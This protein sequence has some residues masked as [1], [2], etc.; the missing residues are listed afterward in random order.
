VGQVVT[1]DPN[2]PGYEINALYQLYNSTNGADWEYQGTGTHWAFTP[3]ANPCADGWAGITCILP[4]PYTTNYINQLNLQQF[5]LQGSLPDA[6]GNFHHMS[7]LVLNYNEITGSIPSTITNLTGLY[8]LDIMVNH[9]TGEIPDVFN[10]MPKLNNIALDYNHLN[11]TIPSTIVSLTTIEYIGLSYNHLN[12]TIPEGFGSLKLL[13][14]IEL[15]SNMLSGSIPASLCGLP[16]LQ[17]LDIAKNHLTGALPAELGA[18]SALQVL[19]AYGNFL[20]GSLPASMGNLTL[21][22]DFTVYDNQLT[23]SLPALFGRLVNL[24]IFQADHNNLNGTFPAGMSN[25]THLTTFTVQSNKFSGTLPGELFSLPLLDDLVLSSNRFNGT[26]PDSIGNLTLV[27]EIALSY[28]ELTGSIP[29]A[30]GKLYMVQSL[31]FSANR[32]VGPLPQGLLDLP[33]LNAFRMFENKLTGPFPEI[34]CEIPTLTIVGL[35][36][37]LFH[38]TLPACISQLSQLQELAIQQNSWTGTLPPEYGDLANLRVITLQFCRSLHGTIPESYAN[39]QSLM[40]LGLTYNSF[41]GTIPT[42]LADLPALSALALGVNEFTGT[43]PEELSTAQNLRAFDVGINRLHGTIPEAYGNFPAAMYLSFSSNNFTGTIPAALGNLPH[44]TSLNLGLCRLTGTLPPELGGL[45][46]LQYLGAEDNLLTGSIPDSYG[47]LR[48]LQYLS[49][50]GNTLTGSIPPSFSGLKSLVSLTLQDN[51]L[52]GNIEQLFDPAVQYAIQTVQLS[53][54]RLTGSIP[55]QVFQLPRLQSLVTIGNCFHGTLPSTMCEAQYLQTLELDALH[56]ATVCQSKLFQGL[57]TYITKDAVAGTVPSCL[58]Q[59]PYLQTLHLSSNALT[60]TLAQDLTITDTLAD[61][62]LSYNKLTGTIP[63]SIQRRPWYNL[64]LS[65]NRLSGTLSADFAAQQ[66]GSKAVYLQYNKLSG[67]LPG[68]MI[69]AVNISVLQSN[70]FTCDADRSDLPQNDPY[71]DIYQCG[72]TTTDIPY[73]EWVACAVV[74]A[75][76]IGFVYLTREKLDAHLGVT[77]KLRMMAEWAEMNAAVEGSNLTFIST[78]LTAL[79]QIGL[80]CMLFSVLLLAP[81][82]A[83]LAVYYGT[84][85]YEYIWSVSVV[86]KAGNAPLALE[87]AFYFALLCIFLVTFV[88]YVRPL[89]NTAD[90]TF[91]TTTPPAPS[92]PAAASASPTGYAAY[93][94][95]LRCAAYIFVN[96][97]V[98]GIVNIYYVFLKLNSTPA[99]QLTISAFKVVWNGLCSPALSRYFLRPRTH[100]STL[101]LFVSLSNTI[102]IPILAVVFVSPDCFY[103]AFV[104]ESEISISSSSEVCIA[105][106]AASCAVSSEVQDTVSFHPPF[107]YNFQCSYVFAEFYVPAFVYVC[108]FSTFGIPLLELTLVTLHKRAVQGTR[109]FALLDRIVPRILKP[110]TASVPEGQVC[111][112]LRPYFDATQFIITQ[113]T[114]LCLLMTFGAVFPPLAASILLTM[115]VTSLVTRIKIG[116]FLRNATDREHSGYKELVEQ[117]CRGVASYSALKKAMWMIIIIS[118]VF[119]A[120][121]MFDTLG[122]S[123]G[124]HGSFWILIVFPLMSCVLYCAYCGVRR[125]RPDLLEPRTGPADQDGADPARSESADARQKTRLHSGAGVLKTITATREDGPGEH[126]DTFN[127]LSGQL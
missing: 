42:F 73:Y 32:M 47:Y 76:V 64:D 59:L 5:N 122:T 7:L 79:C 68:N 57:G 40:Y 88:Y 82:Y 81:L 15:T 31:D 13:R 118:A 23:G 113:V 70:I 86:L 125:V 120:L 11:G 30:I 9:L 116:R 67:E 85:T 17:S 10:Q 60:G 102:V 56:S 94:P 1:A 43:L 36:T 101:E 97:L 84:H 3:T 50:Y 87:F 53:S 63:E 80:R 21:L 41:N 93:E 54:N 74:A 4:Y 96:F 34:L 92:A 55:Y 27:T 98:V 46:S 33:N 22:R 91:E 14:D 8:V 108:L 99:F 103:H 2:L 35:A 16:N 61:L 123:A 44:L 89:R 58:F 12:G 112:P 90:T 18:L 39:L 124:F 37:N 66:P 69:N 75:A 52:I 62:S 104:Q 100:H 127:V 20:Q 65:Y 121:F 105:Q 38:G 114:Y 83:I 19:T 95:H 72:S 119:Y 25:L 126:G 29:E 111:N 109:W 24:Q 107:L 45:Y 6:I 51:H 106:G 78:V 48:R 117:E 26:I 71:V 115:V 77:A 28:N 49:L 110:T